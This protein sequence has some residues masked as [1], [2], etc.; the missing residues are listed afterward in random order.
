MSR[1][2]L[3]GYFRSADKTSE[4]IGTRQA[5]VFRVFATTA[6]FAEPNGNT[7]APKKGVD[8]VAKSPKAP[9]KARAVALGVATNDDA[10]ADN[11]KSGR[12][13][14]LT[15]RVEINLPAGG[16]RETYD[17]IFKSI[18]ANLLDE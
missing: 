1:A 4:I 15:V 11:R 9:K 3:I 2:E 8:R 14:A 7:V 16:T 10:K 17:H 12:D 6:G 5:A 18:R 13:M